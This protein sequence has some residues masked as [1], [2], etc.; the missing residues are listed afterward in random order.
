MRKYSPIVAEYIIP[1]D[2]R[3]IMGLYVSASHLLMH[4]LLHL[5]LYKLVFREPTLVEALET[6]VYG[7]FINS[8]I[9]IDMFTGRSFS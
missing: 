4:I 9:V 6:V 5:S 1:A 7:S 3:Y 8:G 2:I